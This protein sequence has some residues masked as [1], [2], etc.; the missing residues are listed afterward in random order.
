[1]QSTNVNKH[2]KDKTT[3]IKMCLNFGAHIIFAYFLV[4]VE[5]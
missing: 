2:L 3:S 1:M 5:I 4:Y